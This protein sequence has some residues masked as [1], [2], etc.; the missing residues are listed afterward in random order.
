[1]KQIH[2]THREGD[3]LIVELLCKKTKSRTFFKNIKKGNYY[4][5]DKCDYSYVT[6]EDFDFYLNPTK[7]KL[8]LWDYF[9]KDIKE[10][11]CEKITKINGV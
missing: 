6:I 2:K 4:K 8:Y 3:K 7:H 11:R 10:L 9:Y 1:M 5:I